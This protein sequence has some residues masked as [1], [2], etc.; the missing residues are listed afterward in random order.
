MTPGGRALLERIGE[1]GGPRARSSSSVADMASSKRAVSL[2]VHAREARLRDHIS[3]RRSGLVIVSSDNILIMQDST[4]TIT[5]A[6]LVGTREAA[7]LFGVR[8]QNFL[9]DW[10]GRPDFPAPLAR[11]AATRVWSRRA[12]E[13]YRDDRRP[14][15]PLPPRRRHR[16]SAEAARW[17]PAIKRRI[18]R[19][20]A[21]EAI[22]LFGSQA[23][24]EADAR[25]DL[26]LLVVMSEVPDRRRLTAGIYTALEGIPLGTDVIVATPAELAA[27]AT[28]P[29]TVLQ[30]ALAEGATIY[31]RA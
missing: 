25:S 11:L 15:L 27:Y 3:P 10:A 22:V 2:A 13:S 14:T 23:R 4:Q 7:D 5:G 9:R 16:L 30:P 12:I 17:L 19:R 8:P 24:G 18:V 28:V 6:D 26:D 1:W 29:G 31:A 21:P 20:F